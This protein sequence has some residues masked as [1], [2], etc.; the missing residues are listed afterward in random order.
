[1][2][3][4]VKTKDLDGPYESLIRTFFSLEFPNVMPTDIDTVLEGVTAAILS[5]GQVRYGPRPKPESLVS[6]REVIRE[7]IAS[8][9]PIPMLS[10]FGSR[11]SKL[12]EPLDMAEIFA[13]KQLACL[14]HRVTSFYEPGI[15]V[16]IRLED[17]SGPYVFVD[18]GEIS[19]SDE[20]AY[21]GSFIKAVK[22]LGF[23]DFIR[24][25]LE[26]SMFSEKDLTSIAD[27]ML[28]PMLDYIEY[29]DLYGVESRES[30]SAWPVLVT[31]GWKNPIA[32]EQRD[33]Y[34]SRYRSLYPG[35]DLR[36]ATVKLARYFSQ[37][38][39]RGQL[40]GAGDDRSWNG[41]FIRLTF[42]GPVPGIPASQTLRDVYYRT[43]PLRFTEFHAMPWRVKGYLQIADDD[44]VIPK[45]AS[46]KD[47][48]DYQKNDLILEN[49]D[50]SVSVRSDFVVS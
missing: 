8:C 36:G 23:D 40:H 43:L 16:N 30:C 50:T 3:L 5:T 10:P 38:W 17:A 37:A 46:W 39:A 25:V 48:H 44:S 11:K 12:G 21:C 20:A 41:R 18:E 19:R 45:L 42:I 24:P 29:T 35:L 6:I 34:R 1:M 15:Q 4:S 27:T 26:S 49:G 31:L 2:A 14:Q 32:K 22:V 47:V 9:K 33:Y 28:N 13:M 7:A